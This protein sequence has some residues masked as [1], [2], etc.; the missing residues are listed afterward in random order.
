MKHHNNI[1]AFFLGVFVTAAIFTLTP[2]A[3]AMA[4]KMIEVSTGVR[5]YIDDVELRPTDANGNPVE[6]FI[7]N[8][9]TY[10]PARA[11]S[12]SL[13]K[14]VQWD[15]K[16]QSVYIGRHT[17][18]EPAVW[19][20]NLD[21][22]S[23]TKELTTATAQSDN[24]GVTHY[25]CITKSFDRTYKLNGQYSRI[26]GTLYQTYDLRSA[27]IYKDCGIEIYGDGRLLYVNKTTEKTTGFE[28][29]S[30]DVDLTGVLE[31]QIIHHT[32]CNMRNKD[33]GLSLGDVGLWS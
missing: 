12:E 8:G 7:Y 31:L 27:D 1:R 2:S 11:I 4:K 20:T 10:L 22:F 30:F 28:P 23:G 32:S 15:G 9:T 17:G 24:L 29:V 25:H 14:P 18:M 6:V 26:T 21:Y 19:L 5:I 33:E 16:T 3:L 13:G